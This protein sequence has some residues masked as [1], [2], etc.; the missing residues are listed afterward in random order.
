MGSFSF[1]SSTK[2]LAPD[3]INGRAGNIVFSG[4]SSQATFGKGRSH[5][6]QNSVSAIDETTK[7]FAYSARESSAQ[8]KPLY[9]VW[10][11]E[12]EPDVALLLR[13]D[14][15]L[16]RRRSRHYRAL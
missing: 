14:D 12:D 4:S 15:P 5:P 3:P 2:R 1:L 11:R 7:M 13:F 16:H 6:P 10:N 9:S 8:R